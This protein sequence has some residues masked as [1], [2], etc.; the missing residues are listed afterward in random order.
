[1]TSPDAF[2]R[3]H[4][5]THVAPLHAAAWRGDGGLTQARAGEGIEASRFF[6]ELSRSK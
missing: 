6:D 3:L 4:L 5:A 1:M 2:T